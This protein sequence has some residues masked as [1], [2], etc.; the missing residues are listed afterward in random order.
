MSELQI[1]DHVE[2][3][4]KEQQAKELIGNLPQI[5]EE[6]STLELQFNDVL[7]MDLENPETAQ[8]AKKLRLLIQKNRTKGLNVWHKTSKDF[9][10]RG[11][12]FVDAIKRKQVAVNERMEADLKEIE[13]YA[14]IKEQERLADIQ[15]ERLELISPYVEDTTGLDLA[16]MPDD[17]W[18]PYLQSKIKAHEERLEAERKAEEE[19]IAKEKAENEE[20]ERIRKEN[21]QLK[22]EAEERERL[23]KIEREK[24]ESERKT[25]EE[26][27]RKERESYESKIKAEREERQRIELEE[28]A[29]REKLEAELKAKKEAEQ[30]AIQEQ[31]RLK[32][33][34][35]SKGDEDKV[36]DLIADIESLKTKYSFKSK[37]NQKTYAQ[38]S[39][40]LDKVV[41][42]IKTA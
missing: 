7:K 9:F 22:K 34:E 28:R 3:G 20:R 42:H 6:R 39:S 14:E 26:K 33:L 13:D 23:A 32:E 24:R 37:K 18:T 12:Q 27:E 2:Y 10:L 41:N 40:L 15:K 30:K 31:E 21:E 16:S 29:K 1:I 36:K 38:T 11:G 5:V 8:E 19:R 25:R 35:L 4:I 17:V